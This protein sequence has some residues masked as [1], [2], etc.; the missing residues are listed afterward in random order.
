MNV[1]AALKKK[2]SLHTR[3]NFLVTLQDKVCHGF[4]AR[5]KINETKTE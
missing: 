2:K 5:M 4:N 3:L 1:P